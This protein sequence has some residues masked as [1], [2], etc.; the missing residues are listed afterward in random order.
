MLDIIQNLFKFRGWTVDL[1]YNEDT[2]LC[3]GNVSHSINGR[4]ITFR[5]NANIS[6]NTIIFQMILPNR[7]P[8]NTS[9]KTKNEI[10]KALNYINARNLKTCFV[11]AEGCVKQCYYLNL[12]NTII[13][14]EVL[15]SVF[16]LL[17]ENY[18]RF[19]GGL[20]KI[21]SGKISTFEF[22]RLEEESLY[23]HLC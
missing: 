19:Y 12:N 8:S 21:I 16:D 17:L 20:T 1:N 7:I 5:L 15:D 2:T 22:A 11:A 14:Q 3:T 6:A 10:L 4:Y 18:S 9:I 13:T 23:Y